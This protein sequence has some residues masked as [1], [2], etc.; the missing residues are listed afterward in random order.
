V[1]G[2]EH[3]VSDILLGWVYATVVYVV[4]TKILDRHDARRAAAVGAP[5]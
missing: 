4:L 5:S 2:A 3:Y 1:Y